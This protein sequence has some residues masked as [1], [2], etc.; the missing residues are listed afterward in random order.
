MRF[1]TIRG[2]VYKG[3]ILDE[4]LDLRRNEIESFKSVSNQILTNYNQANAQ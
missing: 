1:V 4:Q 3:G 2:F